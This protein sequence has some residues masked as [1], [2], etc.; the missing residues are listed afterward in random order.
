MDL[1]LKYWILVKK[2]IHHVLAWDTGPRTLR[3]GYENAVGGLR[4]FPGGECQR[5]RAGGPEAPRLGEVPFVKH[6]V[7]AGINSFLSDS[8][9]F[10]AHPEGMC[11]K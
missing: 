11:P 9:G 7:R 3:V 1:G 6:F 4:T 8:P 10:R 2:L 5:P